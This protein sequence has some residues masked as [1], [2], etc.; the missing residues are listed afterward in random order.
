VEPHRYPRSGAF[1]E[2]RS[3]GIE[4]RFHLWPADIAGYGLGEKGLE[5]W[6]RLVCNRFFAHH[7]PAW[8]DL[9]SS[10]V[11]Q[12]IRRLI[13]DYRQ[14]GPEQDRVFSPGTKR[15]EEGGLAGGISWRAPGEFDDEKRGIALLSLSNNDN[16]IGARKPIKSSRNRSGSQTHSRALELRHSVRSPSLDTVPLSRRI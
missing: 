10:I 3:Q 9:A 11:L 12:S 2:G 6:A 4:Q 13:R 8:N 1:T 14:P 16:R 7:R 15:A 5:G